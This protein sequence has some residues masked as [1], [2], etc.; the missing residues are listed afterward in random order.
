MKIIRCTANCFTQ[1]NDKQ[2][3]HPGVNIQRPFEPFS[4]QFRKLQEK[5]TNYVQIIDDVQSLYAF[6]YH[7]IEKQQEGI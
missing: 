2:V 5:M 7:M 4:R 1:I 3:L 6:A